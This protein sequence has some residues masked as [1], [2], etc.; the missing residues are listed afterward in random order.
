MYLQIGKRYWLE[1]GIEVV[2]D[3]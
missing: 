2:F 3:K 1:L